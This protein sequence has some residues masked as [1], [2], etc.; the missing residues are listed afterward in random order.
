MDLSMF[1]KQAEQYR[2]TNMII[3]QGGKRIAERHWD[4][5]I[6]R[7]VYSASK[8]FTSMAIGIACGEGLLSLE[9]KLVDVFPD[10]LPA[11][12]SEYLQQ[13]TVRDMLTM[14][15]G[16]DKSYMMSNE[17]PFLKETNWVQYSLAQPFTDAPNTK[18]VYSNVGPHL[19]GILLQRRCGCDLVHYLV[20]RLFTPLEIPLPTWEVDPAGYTFGAGGL[21]LCT[22]ELAKFGQLL[23][24]NG[25]WG[26][27][28]IVPADYVKEASRKQVENGEDGYGYLL[29]RGKD[30]S[31]RADGLYCQYAIVLPDKDAV[32]TVNAECRDG[33][34]LRKS[35]HEDLIPL[36]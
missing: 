4:R 18:F 24:Q 25:R 28:Q 20:P 7:N 21:F 6:R 9:E 10:E 12:P 29:W 11:S 15:L 26:Q 14:C 36:L 34:G 23:L 3:Q 22:S 13:A 27:K 16:Q 35:I 2:V 8:S 1:D 19:A 17:R 30:N 32:I 5:E 31:F 33:D